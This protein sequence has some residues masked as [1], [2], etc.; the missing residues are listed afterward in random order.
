VSATVDEVAVS[1]FGIDV[2]DD[3]AG[4]GTHLG[5]DGLD[6]SLKNLTM[7]PG[8]SIPIHVA[9]R[10]RQG[11]TVA[12]DGSVS[13][14]PAV[15]AALTVGVD[16]LALLPLSPYVEQNVR[17]RLTKGTLSVSGKAAAALAAV[18]EASF[19]GDVAVDMLGLVDAA[20]NKD[21]AGFEHFGLNGISA[22][23]GKEIK[24]S[25][26]TIAL[27]GPYARARVNKDHEI[28]F[29]TLVPPATIR[30]VVA[31]PASAFP[32]PEIEVG[33]IAIERAD[34][35]FTDVSIE[36]NVA[37]GLR[38]FGGRIDGISSHN[39]AKATVD[40]H[41]S[42]D[43][44]G[45]VSIKGAVDALGAK[46]F[47]DLKIDVK[48]VD[49][50]PLSPYSGHFAGYELARGQLVVDTKI[51]LDGDKLDTTNVVTLN[52]FTFGSPV[53]SPD[54]T[55]LPVRLGVALLKDLDGRIVIDLP[56]QGSL[57][58]P[59]FRIGKVVVRVIVNLLT[60]AAVSPFALVGSMFGGGGDELAYQDFSPGSAVL[61]PAEEQKLATL[62][63]ALANR[64]GLSLGIR[65]DFDPAADVFALKRLK[66]EDQVHR[67]V[68]EEKHKA[69]PN[70]PA[71]DAL[72]VTAAEHDAMVKRL[73][74]AKFPPGTQFGTPLPTMPV[75]AAPPVPP[76]GL[77]G[78]IVDAVTF[79]KARQE[80]AQKQAEVKAK[81]DHERQVAEAVAKGL[82]VDEMAGRLA[83]AIAVT[84]D[85][86]RRLA[87]QRAATVRAYFTGTAHVGADRLFLEK[88]SDEG[89]GPRV[90]LTLE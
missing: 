34:M 50:V 74:D 17:A 55:K 60:K 20:H 67:A 38:D 18:P 7:D 90:F 24:V 59:D 72:M 1:G 83:E 9:A 58:D 54:A 53:E 84:Q 21:L 28:N 78:R 70:I 15:K 66:L 25:V 23:A 32:M 3:A 64:P 61:L 29:A 57:S 73:F 79:A 65:G 69:D 87:S 56:V 40:L 36:P 6:V 26:K 33:S 43:G 2:V 13:V 71:P 11:G 45:P 88:A 44:T 49:L 68:W 10:W 63:K 19:E 77:F 81:E 51:A 35:S 48:N 14:L 39:L 86:L 16:H 76:K 46:K 27:V 37:F 5:V 12:V 62:G 31:A 85:D 82:P 89:K 8:A 75:V 47:A 4:P 30:P 42:V 52:Q 22:S 80:R 41:G